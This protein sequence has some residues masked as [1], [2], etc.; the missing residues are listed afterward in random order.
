MSEL[1]G[2]G[3]IEARMDT[4]AGN[5]EVFWPGTLEEAPTADSTAVGFIV[6]SYSAGVASAFQADTIGSGGTFRPPGLFIASVYVPR[7]EGAGDG[8]TE[9]ET[10]AA[11]FRGK[12]DTSGDTKILYR[13]PTI[14]PVGPDGQWY[15]IDV[16]VPYE[17]DTTYTT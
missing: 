6:T 16:E 1:T 14:R 17:R 9:A 15:Q 3:L 13:S 8:A 2:R 11:L 12:T 4:Y 5:L 10:I 7:G